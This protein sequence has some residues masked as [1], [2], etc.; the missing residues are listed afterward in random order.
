MA[1]AM[2]TIVS[3]DEGSGPVLAIKD[4]TGRLITGE[5]I[6][7]GR[8]HQQTE[9]TQVATLKD[10]LAAGDAATVELILGQM[11]DELTRRLTLLDQQRSELSRTLEK[12]TAREEQTVRNVLAQMNQRLERRVTLMQGSLD[13]SDAILTQ[14]QSAKLGAVPLVSKPAPQTIVAEPP[15]IQ[16]GGAVE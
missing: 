10:K 12:L 8:Q 7:L 5:Q 13:R 16:V 2:P 11:R 9:F 3:F 6:E 14:L 15:T 4:A 1:D